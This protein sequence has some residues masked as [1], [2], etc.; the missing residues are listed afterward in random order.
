MIV[1]SSPTPFLYKQT[2]ECPGLCP[3][4]SSPHNMMVSI[5][6]FDITYLTSESIPL[7][8]ESSLPATEIFFINDE[9]AISL[10]SLMFERVHSAILDL[11]FPKKIFS[12][13]GRRILH[14]SPAI[15]SIKFIFT[16]TDALSWKCNVNCSHSQEGVRVSSKLKKRPNQ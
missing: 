5:L 11:E 16:P 13:I 9:L 6:V 14:N 4:V 8:S 10:R 3:T 15:S 12:S 1:P 2:K 7:F